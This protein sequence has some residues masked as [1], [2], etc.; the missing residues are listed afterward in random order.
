MTQ[1]DRKTHLAIA[2]TD[3]FIAKIDKAL[4]ATE[5][6]TGISLSRSQVARM[7]IEAGIK[8]KGL[9]R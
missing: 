8:A 1:P 9:D 6:A 3:E 7:L 2:A 5:A 4:R